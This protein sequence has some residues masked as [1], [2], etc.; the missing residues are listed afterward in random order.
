V[1]R[2]GNCPGNPDRYTRSPLPIIWFGLVVIKLLRY[3]TTI[4]NHAAARDSK[5][6]GATTGV[7][8]TLTESP[9]SEFFPSVTAAT[10]S[11][12]GPT[13]CRCSRP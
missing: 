2:T 9:I 6:E 10:A 4:N 13:F 5:A 11:F 8:A 3:G 12:V 7:F 1:I